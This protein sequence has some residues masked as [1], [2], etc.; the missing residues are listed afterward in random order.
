MMSRAQLVI[1]RKEGFKIGWYYGATTGFILGLALSA[2]L[3][4]IKLT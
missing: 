3:F 1:S 2:L 4:G